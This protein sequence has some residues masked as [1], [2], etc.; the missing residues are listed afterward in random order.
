MQ[1][2][3]GR[4]RPGVP[5]SSLLRGTRSPATVRA[6]VPPSGPYSPK[7]SAAG[8]PGKIGTDPRGGAVQPRRT[9]LYERK[10]NLA[11]IAFS[12]WIGSR[13]GLPAP[14][15]E[16][17]L[18]LARKPSLLLA[19]VRLMSG[20]ITRMTPGGWSSTRRVTRVPCASGSQMLV[21]VGATFPSARGT[22][23]ASRLESRDRH[24]ALGQVKTSAGS[25][26]MEIFLSTFIP[27]PL[28]AL[29]G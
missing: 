18:K 9:R 5:L 29:L 6:W 19:I 17:P 1:R 28:S 16:E 27:T 4:R 26:P 2:G 7:P 10:G 13:S 25:R 23:S 15:L 20:V 12:R 14:T 21:T 8:P 24:R 22:R 11:A 3:A